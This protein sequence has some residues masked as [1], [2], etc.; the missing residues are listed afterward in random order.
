VGK[1]KL[2]IGSGVSELLARGLVSLFLVPVA[3][4]FGVCVGDPLAWIAA[5]CFLVPAFF[6]VIRKLEK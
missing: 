1:A 2:S 5:D 3:G 6:L 4:F